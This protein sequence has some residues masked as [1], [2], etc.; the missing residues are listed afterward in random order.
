M[1]TILELYYFYSL[2]QKYFLI[3]IN[4]RKISSRSN[5]VRELDFIMNI[6]VFFPTFKVLNIDFH[7]TTAKTIRGIFFC[8]YFLHNSETCPFSEPFNFNKRQEFHRARS[9]EYGVCSST[10]GTCS[11][12]IASHT[13]L[14]S[15]LDLFLNYVTI[16]LF[17]PCLTKSC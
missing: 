11:L 10:G 14:D 4:I 3:F 8:F 1:I 2:I 12:K 13:M 9:G 17:R 16:S 15:L 7:Q 6:G 5:R